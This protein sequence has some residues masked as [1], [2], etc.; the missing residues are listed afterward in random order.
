[1]AYVNAQDLKRRKPHRWWHTAIIDDMLAFPLD[2]L[3]VR[4]TRLGYDHAYL[5]VIINSDMFRAAY[6]VRRSS[7]SDQLDAS[8]AHK[9]AKVADKALDILLESLEKKRTTIPFAAL[10]DA[11]LGQNGVL[12]RLGYGVKTGP[13]VQ[14]N[15]DARSATIAP[16]V[17][18]E[19]LA[20]ARK[21]LRANEEVR[22]LNGTATKLEEL[23][24]EPRT[25]LG[26]GADLE[27]R[28]NPSEGVDAARLAPGSE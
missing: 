28:L 12:A 9:T 7:L 5:C 24:N 11:T 26:A 1:M 20:D 13:G 2:D 21:A 19:Q 14:V 25:P 15:V 8:I 23:T 17:S 27:L 4:A 3:K 18:A 16:P 10:A 22:L 6:Q